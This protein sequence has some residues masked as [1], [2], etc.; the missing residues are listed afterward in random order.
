[1]RPEVVPLSGEASFLACAKGCGKPSGEVGD[2]AEV[3]GE[4]L[5]VRLVG[6][7]R[8]VEIGGRVRVIGHSAVGVFQFIT[9]RII[10]VNGSSGLCFLR[11]LRGNSSPL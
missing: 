7:G 10:L 6:I 11:D 8:A 9:I 2:V 4:G 5:P 3:V 1:M